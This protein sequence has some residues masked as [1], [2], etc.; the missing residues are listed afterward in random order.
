MHN[1]DFLTK[2]LTSGCEY[3]IVSQNN[4]PYNHRKYDKFKDSIIYM[5]ID[6]ALPVD[7]KQEDIKLSDL[8][9]LRDSYINNV[10]LNENHAPFQQCISM[11]NIVDG[12][13][14]KNNY[15]DI[16][17]EAL[18]LK[19]DRLWD[20]KAIIDKYTITNETKDE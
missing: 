13:P 19:S 10:F 11:Y 7:L 14:I 8:K 20:Y 5:C 17:I 2:V 15:K 18:A 6:Y 1:I 16:L 4:D 9:K 12:F 3:W